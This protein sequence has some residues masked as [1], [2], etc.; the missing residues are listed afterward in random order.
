VLVVY[1]CGAAALAIRIG[2]VPARSPATS[3]TCRAMGSRR[4]S[5]GSW[6]S[7]CTGPTPGWSTRRH[8]WA[9]ARRRDAHRSRSARR[10]RGTRWVL[11]WP[12]RECGRHPADRRAERQAPTQPPMRL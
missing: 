3:C 9:R 12:E 11:G 5:R 8:R 4:W 10:R 7:R 2:F 6:S 1:A